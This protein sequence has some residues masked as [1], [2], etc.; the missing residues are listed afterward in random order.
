MDISSEN[1]GISSDKLIDYF[2]KQ[3]LVDLKKMV[4]TKEE[5]AKRQGAIAA[6]DQTLAL[7]AEAEAEL[8]K[9]RLQATAMIDDAKA[10][11]AKSKDASANA[12]ARQKKVEADEAAFAAASAAK[13][14][15]LDELEKTLSNKEAYLLKLD[16]DLNKRADAL[17]NDEAALAARIKAFQEK[18]AN[19]SA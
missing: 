15:E 6:V 18:V 3:F 14:K 9:A 19:L 16:T 8:E 5:L 7:K 17:A 13:Q 11:D 10:R 1:G 4:E 2:T 12:A